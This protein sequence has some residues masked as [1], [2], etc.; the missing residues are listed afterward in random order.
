LTAHRTPCDH[1]R[2]DEPPQIDPFDRHRGDDPC[3]G[4]VVSGVAECWGY[5]GYGEIGDGSVNDSIVPV[6]V[7]GL[8]GSVTAFAVGHAHTCAL[9]SGTPQCWG[10]N[11]FGS[12]GDGTLTNR[13]VPT[14]VADPTTLKLST[15]ASVVQG[16]TLTLKVTVTSGTGVPTGTVDLFIDGISVGS[17]VL[18]AAGKL[19]AVVSVTHNI[20]KNL[21][22]TP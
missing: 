3:R 15:A 19:T 22:V 10:F 14:N 9:V 16:G 4:A 18:N 11:G 6:A 20:P 17:G 13:H 7:V 8:S 1:P 12:L 5:N 2:A 21:T